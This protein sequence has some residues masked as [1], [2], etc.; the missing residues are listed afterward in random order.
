MHF[1]GYQWVGE[2]S[3]FDRE[4]RR[5]LP[6]EP[7]PS[8]DAVAGAERSEAYHVLTE[9]FLNSP[10]PP[11]EVALWL[12]KPAE[13]VS[14]SWERADDAAGWLGARLA[15][16]APR[17]EPDADRSPAHLRGLVGRLTGTL[18]H[19]GDVSLGYYLGTPVFLS[20]AVVACSP[21]RAEAGLP[22]P[23]KGAA[24][25]VADR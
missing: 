19:G 13:L 20:L 6:V 22:C 8:T 14:G 7:W 15:A 3:E 17:F 4:S 11:V 9:E 12:L 5:R 25:L 18:Q 2:K 16:Y 21:E 10:V 1:H 24:A 23:A